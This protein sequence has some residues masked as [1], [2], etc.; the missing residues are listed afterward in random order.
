MTDPT[1]SGQGWLAKRKGA[2]GF[3]AGLVVAGLMLGTYVLGQ[4]D[5]PTPLRGGGDIS[6]TI[7]PS[8][9]TSATPSPS[10]SPTPSIKRVI[11]GS[12]TRPFGEARG[13]RLSLYV[14]SKKRARTG[15]TLHR[16]GRTGAFE[17][18]C[19]DWASG[20]F[21]IY[22]F[23]VAIENATDQPIRI[24][25]RQFVLMARS[26]NT[27]FPVN[28]RDEADVP[29]QWMPRSAPLP[30]EAYKAGYVAFAAKS[31]YVPG[32]LSYLDTSQTL[33]VKLVGKHSSG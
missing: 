3:L 4:M 20:G 27:F 30:P 8:N 28:L 9:S 19:D 18:D 13:E 29:E 33:T 5:G 32:R 21:D 11:E 16:Y 10:P 24:R 1:R 23:R 22:I 12:L 6:V 26:G 14:G 31:D 17:S 15:C 2:L 7:S 25:L